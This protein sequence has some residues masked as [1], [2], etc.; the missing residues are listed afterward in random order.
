M[1]YTYSV[2]HKEYTIGAQA[3]KE[4]YDLAKATKNREG[5]NVYRGSR[6]LYYG[7]VIRDYWKTV[8]YDTLADG[9]KVILSCDIDDDE[10]GKITKGNVRILNPDGK[11]GAKINEWSISH[12]GIY[13]GKMYSIGKTFSPHGKFFNRNT[14]KM[15]TFGYGY[16]ARR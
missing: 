5:I 10:H 9:R 14:G 1:G 12:N 7:H 4:A 2:N 8:W 16:D 3:L 6:V 13:L 11:L 15:N